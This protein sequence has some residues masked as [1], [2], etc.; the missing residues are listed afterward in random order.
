MI[1]I[2]FSCTEAYHVTEPFLS[3]ILLERIHNKENIHSFEGH[4]SKQFYHDDYEKSDKVIDEIVGS[5]VPR[6]LFFLDKSRR[7]YIFDEKNILLV[8]RLESSPLSA[9]SASE[10]R[11]GAPHT[12]HNNQWVYAIGDPE[13]VKLFKSL[14]ID[15]DDT[16]VELSWSFKNE[17]GGTETAQFF[18]KDANIAHDEFYP[19]IEEGVE[20]YINRYLESTSPVLLMVGPPGTGKTSLIRH[21]LLRKKMPTMVTFDEKIITEDKYF[22]NF[23]VSPRYKLLV[24]EDADIALTSRKELENKMMSKFLNIS[25]GLIPL[26][27]KKIIFSTNIDNIS[28]VDSALTRP[29]RCFDVLNFRPLTYNES[30][31]AIEVAGIDSTLEVGQEYTLTEILNDKRTKEVSRTR[32]TGFI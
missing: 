11:S 9:H 1:D 15:I 31:K 23:M 24:I 19:F 6:Q 32:R 12:T 30:K 5:N 28:Q 2:E 26:H 27:D 17:M 13:F 10:K 14:K 21:L 18:L 29:G 3:K 8:S 7:V 22:I 16:S 25:D 4:V 20:S